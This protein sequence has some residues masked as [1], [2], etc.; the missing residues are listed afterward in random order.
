MSPT[1]T[2][3]CTTSDWPCR[4]RMIARSSATPNSGASTSTTSG[5]AI[6]V[7]QPHRSVGSVN[8]QYT[9]A[10]EHADRALGEV[11]DARRR[12]HDDQAARRHRVDAG[13]RQREH[14]ACSAGSCR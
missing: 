12:V 8:C 6:H 7:G 4:W 1:V 3:S 11:E 5:N 10:N 2:M 9:Y 14:H 13:E